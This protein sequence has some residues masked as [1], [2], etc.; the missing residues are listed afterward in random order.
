MEFN[1]QFNGVGKPF[2][3]TEIS[4]NIRTEMAVLERFLLTESLRGVA[5]RRCI[6][7]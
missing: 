2:V 7:T 5:V 3:V 6:K 1:G 4:P